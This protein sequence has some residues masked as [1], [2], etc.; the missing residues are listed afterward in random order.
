MSSTSVENRLQTNVP[1][2]LAAFSNAQD[3]LA[4]SGLSWLRRTRSNALSRFAELGF[5]TQK[6]E[7]WRFTPVDPIAES[8]F[9]LAE[10]PGLLDVKTLEKLSL[11]LPE[12]GRLVFVDGLY[13]PEL[14]QTH[15][16]PGIRIGSLA[17]LLNSNP[18]LVEPLI[19]GKTQ[20]LGPFAAL[21]MGFF[22]DGAFIHL[23]RNA[24]LS[25]PLHVAFVSTGAPA[26]TLHHHGDSP[27]QASMTVNGMAV[28]AHPKVL[29][30]AEEGTKAVIIE[31]F[32]AAAQ[33]PYFTNV[34]TEMVIG[35]NAQIE[36]YKLQLES[37][38][39]F[40]VASS[41]IRQGRD[42]SFVSH[43]ISLGGVLVRND[44]NVLLEAEGAQCVLNGLY[45]ASGR[46][47]VD[48]HTVI[49]HLKPHGRSSELYKGVLD[50]HARAVFSGSIIVRPDAQ[51]TS[52]MVY[53]KNLLLSEHGLV[54]TKPD[55]KI[56]ANDVQCKH[57]AT[58]G[59]VSAEALFYLRSRGIGQEAA[60]KMLVHAFAS[61]MLDRM[62]VAE[63]KESLERWLQDR[64][65]D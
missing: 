13:S 31:E 33:R 20:D 32:I 22:Q 28:M 64:L 59:Q 55:F 26:K 47:H 35:D 36:H 58:I 4:G 50:G 1:F 42:S 11:G 63:I 24:I 25:Q 34:V 53:N 19:A 6:N 10:E 16:E 44:L 60:R 27:S 7:D 52:A 18:G 49:D 14:S 57:G 46:Q 39:A 61:E 9:A 17:S 43:S 41:R 45:L 40:H 3:A 37:E 65:A 12:T 15:L 56:H 51:K 5:P 2:L 62:N 54:H 30:L 48:N 23:P 38:Q 21:N 8:C 29:L